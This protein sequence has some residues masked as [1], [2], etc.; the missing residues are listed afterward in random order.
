MIKKQS[1]CLNLLLI[2]GLC[3]SS[4]CYAAA[5]TSHSDTTTTPSSQE[6]QKSPYEYEEVYDGMTGQMLQSYKSNKETTI[7]SAVDNLS[8]ASGVEIL[9]GV[10][11]TEQSKTINSVELQLQIVRSQLFSASKGSD[12]FTMTPREL[13]QFKPFIPIT[14]ILTGTDKLKA[15]IQESLNK[16]QSLEQAL[17]AQ[18]ASGFPA[19]LNIEN[20]TLKFYF[21]TKQINLKK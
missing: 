7:K 5:T 12:V 6:Q 14:V 21:Q 20:Y 1:L 17:T 4:T 13:I 9:V 19:V 16:N 8:F 10:E 11:D 3:L 18:D 15:I 2:G